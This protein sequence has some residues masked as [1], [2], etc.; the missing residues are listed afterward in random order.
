MLNLADLAA[1]TALAAIVQ[2][3]G[4]VTEPHRA[5]T[6]PSPIT[7]D[8]YHDEGWQRSVVFSHERLSGS[9]EGGP[10]YIWMIEIDQRDAPEPIR[11]PMGEC[12]GVA[13]AVAI[14]AQADFGQFVLPGLIPYHGRL[15]A[16]Y[17][18]ARYRVHGPT[19][20]AEG[21]GGN[22]VIYPGAEMSA[23]LN[24]L[25]GLVRRC[26]GLTPGGAAPEASTDRP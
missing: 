6:I 1:A 15:G 21:F 20:D 22:I 16:R 17:H 9:N 4:V 26:A 2:T 7:Y 24:D 25:D 13:E 23:A 3:A 5:P 14:V 12:E 10:A 11:I 19:R 8:V 18:G